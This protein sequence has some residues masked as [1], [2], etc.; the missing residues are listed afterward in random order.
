MFSRG[1]FLFLVNVAPSP[2]V[3]RPPS[4]A[5]TGAGQSFT[6]AI[7]EIAPDYSQRDN[8]LRARWAPSH[9]GIERNET[10]DQWAKEPNE[11]G[12]RGLS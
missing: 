6:V 4:R 1:C 8:T 7:I 3:T 2:V 11:C 5:V 12:G 10:A 9:L